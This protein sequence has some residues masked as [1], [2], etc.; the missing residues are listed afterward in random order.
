MFKRNYPNFKPLT[1]SEIIFSCAKRSSVFIFEPNFQ[2]IG[3]GTYGA[4]LRAEWSGIDVAVKLTDTYKERDSFWAE[5][6]HLS[7]V[8]HPNIIKLYGA[9]VGQ[10]VST[11]QPLV[12]CQSSCWSGV[13]PGLHHNPRKFVCHLRL[14]C[15]DRICD[16]PHR[17]GIVQLSTYIQLCPGSLPVIIVRIEDRVVQHVQCPRCGVWWPLVMSQSSK[18]HVSTILSIMSS[19]IPSSIQV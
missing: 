4:V 10:P 11:I 5:I 14:W 12:M 7:R 8:N 1:F 3:R 19:V 9:Y 16:P 17:S 18:S 6:K 2:I 13:N 15:M